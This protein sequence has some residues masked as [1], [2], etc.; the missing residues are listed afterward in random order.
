MN[1]QINRIVVVLGFQVDMEELKQLYHLTPQ[2]ETKED[3]KDLFWLDVATTYLDYE[4]RIRSYRFGNNWIVGMELSVVH[5][6]NEASLLLPHTPHDIFETEFS[7]RTT[8]FT[9]WANSLFDRETHPIK[10]FTILN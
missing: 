7:N 2:E 9:K 1:T 4:K 8:D 3:E 6:T 5:L 10:F